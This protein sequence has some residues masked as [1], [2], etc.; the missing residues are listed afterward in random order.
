MLPTI[1]EFSRKYGFE[2]FIVVADS[3]LMNN[4]NTA[5]LE[6]QGCKYIK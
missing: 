4:A 6:S 5:E 1:N 2:N 3:G